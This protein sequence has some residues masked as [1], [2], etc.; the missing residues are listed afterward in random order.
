M[1]SQRYGGYKSAKELELSFNAIKRILNEAKNVGVKL[2]NITGGEP[3]LRDDI[4]NVIEYGISLGMI[5]YPTTKYAFSKQQVKRLCD[6]GLQTIGVSF[7][8]L[9]DDTNRKLHGT[10]KIKNELLK[11]I[12]YLLSC[13]IKPVIGPVTNGLNYQEY[14]DFVKRLKKLGVSAFAPMIIERSLLA[15]KQGL[16]PND[17]SIGLSPI[18]REELNEQFKRVHEKYNTEDPVPFIPR[19]FGMVCPAADCACISPEGFLTYCARTPD[20]YIGSL[21]RKGLMDVWRSKKRREFMRPSRNKFKGTQ[22][23][24]CEKFDL[25]NKL[26]RCYYFYLTKPPFYQPEEKRLCDRVL[27]YNIAD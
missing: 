9:E 25:C 27:K 16:R 17:G 14:E 20:L 22:C 19:K 5:V 8:S 2:I 23:F 7:D 12:E 11:S 1:V 15:T 26:G 6:T 24:D 18:G 4:Y 10:V 21:K 13:N 3:F